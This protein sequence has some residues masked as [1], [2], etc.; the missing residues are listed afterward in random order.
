MEISE[1]RH[2]FEV[3]SG[4]NNSVSK[5]ERKHLLYD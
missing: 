5:G 3:V 2:I 1:G 4:E